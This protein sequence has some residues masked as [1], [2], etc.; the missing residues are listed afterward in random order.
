MK[1]A[2]LLFPIAN[3]YGKLTER[4]K[5]VKY[6]FSDTGLLATYPER[7]DTALLENAVALELLRRYGQAN[8]FY[9]A[10]A[11]AKVDF[12]VPSENLAV[13]VC[14][15]L[16]KSEKTYQRE[17]SSLEH[18]LSFRPNTQCLILT[19]GDRETL[20]INGI[21][22]PVIPAWQ[23]VLAGASHPSASA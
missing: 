10:D 7:Y 1:E 5:A 6:Y 22:I 3:A 2:F 18:F 8:V 17:T 12:Y 4:L 13:Q 23:W 16:R 20:Q 9:Y 14:W 15:Q 11:H 19:M 21:R